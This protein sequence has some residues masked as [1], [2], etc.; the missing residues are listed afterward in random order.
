MWPVRRGIPG[1][2]G[3]RGPCPSSRV[4][5]LSPPDA[6][7][8]PGPQRWRN[9]SFGGKKGILKEKVLRGGSD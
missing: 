9:A 2:A 7:R 5:Y 3:G 8:Q 1:P 6:P 4:A